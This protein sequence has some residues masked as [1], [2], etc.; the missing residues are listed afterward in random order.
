MKK[1]VS[2]KDEATTAAINM[3][4]PGLLTRIYVP[5]VR[6]LST[7]NR[8]VRYVTST[9]DVDGHGTRVMDWNFER[10]MKNPVVLWAHSHA[11][12][13]VGRALSVADDGENV[14]SD[15]QFAPAEIYDLAGTLY[16]LVENDYLRGV[17]AAFK[18][19]EA[20][21]N[22]ELD[23]I[24]LYGNELAE[25]SLVGVPSNANTLASAVRSGMIP[26]DQ[27]DLFILNKQITGLKG[28]ED[29]EEL[30]SQVM[31]WAAKDLWG[32]GMA[33]EIR[34][35]DESDEVSEEASEESGGADVASL[36]ARNLELQAQIEHLT[37]KL[38]DEEFRCQLLEE[39]ITS[40]GMV[41]ASAASE[42]EYAATIR[43]IAGIVDFDVVNSYSTEELADLAAIVQA[44]VVRAGAMLS[45]KNRD[46]LKQVVRIVE[47]LLVEA[48]DEEYSS[49]EEAEEESPRSIEPPE[50]VRS[51]EEKI[52]S[53]QTRLEA[54]SDRSQA[55]RAI[56]E[57][58]KSASRQAYL[59]DL[60]AK[61]NDTVG[62]LD[63]N[64]EQ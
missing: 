13:P 30:R 17:S 59:E 50:W 35:D 46:S 31:T 42:S 3:A 38:E 26:E 44:S 5:Q 40:G 61:L 10:Y 54:R 63:G 11:V 57:E 33:Y 55:A 7:E 39:R 48:N 41:D 29:I 52:A 37:K 51:I 27:V 32:S 20:K 62:K 21:R 64:S 43:T 34:S 36:E 8:I 6:V 60:L 4:N 45:K 49:E 58:Q 47:Q 53:L 15:I 24:D 12:P 18:P 16:R 23:C 2:K 22:K 56:T 14:I 25:Q 28:V 19:R 1:E 9:R